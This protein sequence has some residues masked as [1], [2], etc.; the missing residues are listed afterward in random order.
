MGHKV[1]ALNSCVLTLLEKLITRPLA[2]CFAS[3]DRYIRSL[4]WWLD[5]LMR[6]YPTVVTIDKGAT[7][8]L[9]VLCKM[10]KFPILIQRNDAYEAM[11]FTE[12][13]AL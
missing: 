5:Y 3:V 6:M 1:Y 4:G 7:H 2:H 12:E 8:R 10:F 13:I 11:K 9:A